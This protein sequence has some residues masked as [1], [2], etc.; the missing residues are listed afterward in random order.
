LEILVSSNKDQEH[1]AKQF[2]KCI[3]VIKG[4]G[5]KVGTLAKDQATGQFALDWKKA[6]G[7]I[8]KDVQEID[9]AQALS[10]AAFAA[11]DPQELV[12]DPRAFLHTAY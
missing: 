1:N 3:E 9:V 12:S 6:L 11:K 4:A 2:E 8:S 10:A 7:D 5:K